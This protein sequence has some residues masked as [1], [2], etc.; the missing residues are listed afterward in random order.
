MTYQYILQLPQHLEP[1]LRAG[2]IFVESGVARDVGSKVIVAHL[3]MAGPQA[4]GALGAVNPAFAVA[5]AALKITSDA[6]KLNKIIRLAQEIKSLSTINLAVSGATLGVAV[7][8]FAVVLYQLE[9]INKKLDQISAQIQALDAK[10]SS[11]IED[12]LS[13]QI[14]AVERYTKN[15]ITLVH[16][17]DRLGWS[18][19]L[20]TQIVLLLDG[21]EA[22]MRKII[23]KFLG[24]YGNN[25]SL[26][27]AQCLQ[28]A[29]A[30]LLK[31]YLTE[32]YLQKKSLDHPALRLQTL[33]YFSQ[34]LC[35][36][37]LLDQLY[38]EYLVSKEH[39]FTEGE[40]DVI[41]ALY[42]YGCQNTSNNVNVHYEILKTTP[43]RQF[44]GWQK[45]LKASDQPLIWLDHR[46]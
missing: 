39:R 36:P 46:P 22:A 8:G 33:D 2:K 24:R 27:L 6:T 30:S 11:I 45:L 21:V 13:E 14:E 5:G 34:Q 35:A 29:Y 9:R 40:L 15:C 16:Q 43:V 20:D 41:L 1:A 10:V 25:I 7:A 37:E 26:E 23:R 3:E 44:N 4:L 17:L 12:G 38:E 32:L 18:D 31:A 42:R 28:S 19:H